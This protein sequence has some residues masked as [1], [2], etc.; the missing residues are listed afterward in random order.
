MADQFSAL[1]L[2]EDDGKVSSVVQD[3]GV[4]ELPDG[5]VFFPEHE[6]WFEPVETLAETEDFIL[7]RWERK[8]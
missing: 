5:D 7:R 2:N 8:A 3:M 1:V 6:H 4:D